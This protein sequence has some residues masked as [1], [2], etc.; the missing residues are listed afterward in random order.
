MSLGGLVDEAVRFNGVGL[1]EVSSAEEG[2]KGFVVH[3]A[4][5]P[6]LSVRVVYPPSVLNEVCRCAIRLTDVCLLHKQRTLS[7]DK[8]LKS[9]SS[10]KRS[11]E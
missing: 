11:E 8:M 1:V 3:C 6:L 4:V 10:H 7:A 9:L 5:F 2:R